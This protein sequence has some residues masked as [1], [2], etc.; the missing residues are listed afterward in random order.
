[1]VSGVVGVDG[2]AATRPGLSG[3]GVPGAHLP[4]DTFSKLTLTT[5][6]GTNYTWSEKGIA[7]PGEAKKYTSKPDYELSQITPPPNWALRFPDGYTEQNPPPDLSADEHFQ[8]WMR[9]AG[10][11]TFTKLWGRNDD[12]KLL[13]GSYEI[14]VNLSA[15]A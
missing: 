9:T 3:V 7:W 2:R 5:D 13:K 8:N 10:L 6:S 14:T 11:P 12:T 15:L 4:V 1:M